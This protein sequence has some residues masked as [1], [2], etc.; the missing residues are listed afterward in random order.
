MKTNVATFF[1]STRIGSSAYSTGLGIR[2][3]TS[4][5]TNVGDHTI[6]ETFKNLPTP[7]GVSIVEYVWI[8]KKKFFF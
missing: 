1:R 8:G 4:T 7:P 2:T 5:S 6:S 3:L